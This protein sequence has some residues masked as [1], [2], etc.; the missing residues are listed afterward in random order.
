M[1]FEGII[2]IPLTLF[3]SFLGLAGVIYFLLTKLSPSP[4]MVSISYCIVLGIS[5]FVYEVTPNQE[6]RHRRDSAVR[7]NKMEKLA[8]ILINDPVAGLSYIYEI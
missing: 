5:F 2:L 4:R 8:Q 6:E 3:V 7:E 1:S